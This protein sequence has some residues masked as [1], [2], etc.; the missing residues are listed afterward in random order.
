MG[1]PVLVL[2]AETSWLSLSGFLVHA[3]MS[4]KGTR[5]WL[6][7]EYGFSAFCLLTFR[8]FY[9]DV[10]LFPWGLPVLVFQAAVLLLMAKYTRHLWIDDPT[11]LSSR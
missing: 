10:A 9:Q 3:L 1:I 6:S 11:R 4:P 7:I 2:A 5:L 8:A